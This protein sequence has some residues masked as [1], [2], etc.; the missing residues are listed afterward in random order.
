MQ[1]ILTDQQ[2][3]W[4]TQA[5]ELAG[6]SMCEGKR[7]GC[8]E[9]N[10]FML[11]TAPSMSM[12]SK[13]KLEGIYSVSTPNIL[14]EVNILICI[15]K[16]YFLASFDLYQPYGFSKPSH[17]TIAIAYVPNLDVDKVKDGFRLYR[18]EI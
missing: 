9:F 11:S 7:V 1:T 17:S 8:A 14:Q 16:T 5:A 2:K 4:I 10:E 3:K 6:K 15:N 18:V 12:L 13:V